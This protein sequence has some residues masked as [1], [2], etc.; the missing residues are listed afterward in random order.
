M[1]RAPPVPSGSSAMG[2]YASFDVAKPGPRRRYARHGRACSISSTPASPRPHPGRTLPGSIEEQ[3]ASCGASIAV[4]AGTRITAKPGSVHGV[5]REFGCTAVMI[6]PN[7]HRA[8]FLECPRQ[9]PVA[10]VAQA[11]VIR[12]EAA[13]RAA[14]WMPYP[15]GGEGDMQVLSARRAAPRSLYDSQA[16]RKSSWTA[17]HA[18]ARAGSSGDGRTCRCRRARRR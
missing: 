12:L 6:N 17:P 2:W 15:R 10:P 13:H 11:V 9:S 7:G 4:A 1:A 3:L 18:D 16:F 14:T 8:P 5:V